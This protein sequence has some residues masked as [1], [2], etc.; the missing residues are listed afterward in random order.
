MQLNSTNT[1]RVSK[2]VNEHTMQ[3][4]IIVVISN[5]YNYDFHA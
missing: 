3:V 5:K 2:Y 4:L 1:D